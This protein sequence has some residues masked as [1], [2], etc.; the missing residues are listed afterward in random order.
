MNKIITGLLLILFSISNTFAENKE[1][2]MGSIAMD[3]PTMMYNKLIP[4]TQYLSKE[5][6]LNIQFKS[7]L[8]I[9][10]T[11]NDLTSGEVMIS[12]LSPLA[13]INARKKNNN[14]EAL[15]SPITYGKTKF[16]LVIATAINSPYNTPNDLIGKSFA[17]GD[18]KALLQKAVVYKTGLKN[19]NF[20][21]IQYLNHL[22]N[23]AKSILAGDF[24]AGILNNTTF[25]DF[26][27]K[28]L[29]EIY[30]SE[31]MQGFVIAVNKSLGQNNILK[32]ENAFLNLNLKNNRDVL[33]N[34]STGCTG[35]AKVSDS[36]YDPIRKIMEVL[37]TK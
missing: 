10:T 3:S 36:T 11:I 18:P 14:I 21:K 17:Y 26:K 5:T 2:H 32:I 16:T 33:S 9:D 24:D 22:D 23:I 7:S 1:I 6:G 25:K 34:L 19:E 15:V 30:R 20:S 13:Y 35:F 37:P 8:N 27:S 28:G 31:P 4:L 29:K 12:Y